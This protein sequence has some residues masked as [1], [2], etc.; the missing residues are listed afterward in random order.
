MSVQFNSPAVF[1]DVRILEYAGID[2][3]IPL[4]VAT[5][6]SG[7]STISSSGPLT[8]T[9]ATDLLVAANVVQTGTDPAGTAGFT[10]RVITSD[11]DI[12]EDSVVTSVGTY[13]ASTNLSSSGQWVMQMAAF[14]AADVSPPT[15]PGNL[16][17]TAVS[18]TEIDLSWSSVTDDVNVNSFAVER[19]Q[20]A[21]CSSFAVMAI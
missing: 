15:M 6:S 12:A 1:P 18:S 3:G 4:D 21:S 20:G 5:G 19:C 14:R 10:S 13:N 9:R 17:A 7:D 16:V 8:T 2:R 11:G